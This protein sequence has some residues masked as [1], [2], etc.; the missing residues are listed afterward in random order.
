MVAPDLYSGFLRAY[1]GF[2]PTW[3]RTSIERATDD[4]RAC[5]EV[6]GPNEL[7]RILADVDPSADVEDF[8][9]GC[10]RMA[11][12]QRAAAKRG[13]RLRLAERGSWDT[14]SLGRRLGPVLRQETGF[15][16]RDEFIDHPLLQRFG[17]RSIVAAT[18]YDQDVDGDLGPELM[19]ELVAL[20]DA[21]HAEAVIKLAASKTGIVRVRLA[22]RSSE[23]ILHDLQDDE[24]GLGWSLIHLDG[25]RDAFRIQPVIDMAH[26]YRFFVVDGLVVA[27]AGCIE[28]HTPYDRDEEFTITPDSF[29]T[30]AL[31]CCP[32]SLFPPRLDTR[33]R[34]VRGT[35][36]REGTPSVVHRPDVVGRLMAAATE[37]VA[38][39]PGT[40]ALDLAIDRDRDQVVVV[41]LN[42][43][44]NAGLYAADADRVQ[45]ALAMASDKGYGHLDRPAD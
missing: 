44:T 7:G 19:G 43:I 6:L 25:V 12:S 38:S 45:L 21:G 14:E 36:G 26:E 30:E 1:P 32:R 11:A 27:G 9:E 4:L 20:R 15:H 28:E 37:M 24:S 41:E 29:V 18:S 22:G 35:L 42:G 33:T 34:E 31:V 17:G 16:A 2:K 10:A 3:S 40:Y 23:E 13:G 8:W 39:C 5:A